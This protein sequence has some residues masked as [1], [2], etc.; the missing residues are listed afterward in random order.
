MPLLTYRCA[1]AALHTDAIILPA[2]VRNECIGGQLDSANKQH[3]CMFSTTA[4][5]TDM[6]SIK[7]R[8]G[9]GLQQLP[10]YCCVLFAKGLVGL[11][12]L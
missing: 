10:Y 11:F 8:G 12:A 6:R 5:R 7:L 1:Q 2:A 4:A 3:L 9:R